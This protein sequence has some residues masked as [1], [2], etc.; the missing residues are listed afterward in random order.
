MTKSKIYVEPEVEIIAI[1]LEGNVLAGSSTT[2][3]SSGEGI[4]WGDE[5]DP[6]W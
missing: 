6:G 2:G 5:F 1:C 3:K 4:T